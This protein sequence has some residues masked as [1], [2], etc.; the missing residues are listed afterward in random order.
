MKRKIINC[1]HCGKIINEFS[2]AVDCSEF[3]FS[4]DLCTECYHKLANNILEFIST[5]SKQ[6]DSS[7]E[8]SVDEYD[9]KDTESRLFG[10][11]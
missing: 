10:G 7:T 6:V 5:Y 2:D 3:A 9:D 8:N 4:F 11:I 1:D